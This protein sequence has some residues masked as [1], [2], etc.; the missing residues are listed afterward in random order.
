MHPFILES[1]E[2]CCSM[3]LQMAVL[4]QKY[5][6][7]PPTSTHSRVLS[8]FY[9]GESAICQNFALGYIRAFRPD[10]TVQYYGSRVLGRSHAVQ[11]IPPLPIDTFKL[12]FCEIGIM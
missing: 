2:D 1:L 12:K 10:R 6:G 8:M 3:E 9:F 11:V 5:R 4:C 7:W